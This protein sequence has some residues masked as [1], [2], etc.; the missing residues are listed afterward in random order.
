MNG[1]HFYKYQ[2]TGNDFVMIDNREGLFPQQDKALIQRLCHRKYGVGGDGLILLQD[3]EVYD[4]EMIY[5]NADAT[6]S[7][8]GNGSRCAVHLAHHLQM[9]GQHCQFYAEDGPH[10]ATIDEQ[11]LIHVRMV[12][13]T[14]MDEV[15]GGYFLNTGTRHYV[16]P[17]EKLSDFDVFGEGKKIRYADAF[18]PQGT[19]ASFVEM[20][21]GKAHMRIYERGVEDE[22]L[23]SGTGVTAVA[24]CLAR[25]QG[26]RSPVS[27]HTRGGVLQVSFRQQENG[28]FTD[29]HMIGPAVMV[30]E[31]TVFV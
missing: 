21:G 7:M 31:G 26:L 28:S 12:D 30:F 29:V 10:H 19:N 15:A 6:T 5:F 20:V 14:G 8:C 2:G 3:H 1:I 4:F 16:R 23:S 13:V 9:I 22:T 17:V 24:I 25:L 11:G 27:V 18:M